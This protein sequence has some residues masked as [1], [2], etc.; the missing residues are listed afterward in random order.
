SVK[1]KVERG[2]VTL[3]GHVEWHYQLQAASLDIQHLHGVLGLANL[4][5]LKPQVNVADIS[6]GIKQALTRSWYTRPD[7]ISVT[8]DAGRV[9][10]TGIVH[11]PHA[12]FV[13]GET[14]W[15]ARGATWVENDLVIA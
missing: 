7:T 14:A 11:S 4:I 12:R 9:K 2:F 8:A 10:L 1:V 13:A 3:T 6:A 5:T 15:N